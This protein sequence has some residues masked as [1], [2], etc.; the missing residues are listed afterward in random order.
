METTK[1][2]NALSREQ[3]KAIIES[4]NV[5]NETGLTPRQ[6]LDIKNAQDKYIEHL[7]KITEKLETDVQ[8]RKELRN[9][10]LKLTDNGN[11]SK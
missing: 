1:P 9:N 4:I 6:L 5:F 11:N 10:L 8:A 7:E 3:E 2:I